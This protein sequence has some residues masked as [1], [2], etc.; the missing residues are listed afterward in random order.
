MD[1]TTVVPPGATCRLDA[2]GNL[3]IATS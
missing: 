1:A 3:I 2:L